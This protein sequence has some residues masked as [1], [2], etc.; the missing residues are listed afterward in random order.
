MSD[1]LCFDRAVDLA[2]ALRAGEISATEVMEAHLARVDAVDR[3]RSRGVTVEVVAADVAD[4]VAMAAV[5]DRC[6]ADLPPLRG[7]VH[8]AAALGECPIDSLDAATLAP[9]LAPKVAGTWILDELTQDAPLDFAIPFSSTT[10]LWGSAGLA[11][12]AAANAVLDAHA[13]ASRA[14]GRPWTSINWGTW[15]VMRVASDEERESVERGGL[16]P[17]PVTDALEAINRAI[18][19]ETPQT[20]VVQADFTTLRALYETRRA[21]PF[22]GAL[23]IEEA[24]AGVTTTGAAGVA[25]ELAEADAADRPGLLEAFL[26]GEVAR[27]L[28]IAD[29]T[30]IDPD[31]GLFEMGMDSLMSVELKGRI[32]H[33]LGLSLPSTL[34]FNY[35]TVTDLTA[36]TTGGADAAP[37]AEATT[38]TRTAAATPR[39]ELADDLGEDELEALLAERLA[40]LRQ[41]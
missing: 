5:I 7:I 31:Q 15:E 28:Q 20:V 32:E 19:A 23:G 2:A 21:R 11:H 25:A 14:A 10:A 38:T 24:E 17:L 16:K 22:F 29:P 41:R 27:S 39:P 3:L 33:G 35:P 13:H 37:A 30:R 26:R 12:Y 6:G 36:R 40:G 4:R 1:D 18:A 34:T 9:M 8:A